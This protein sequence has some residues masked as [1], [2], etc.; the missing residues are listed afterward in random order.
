[1]KTKHEA[2]PPQQI[3]AAAYQLLGHKGY[4]ATTIKE[5]ARAADVAPGLVH[6]YFASKDDLLLAV[7]QEAAKRYVAEVEKVGNALATDT[8]ME[9]AFAQTRD[10]VN[11]EPE[12]YRL[13]YELLSLGLRN[14]KLLAGLSNLL[15]EGRRCIAQVIRQVVQDSQVDADALSPVLLACFDGLA[16]QKLAD[17]SFDLEGAYQMLIQMF[18]SQLGNG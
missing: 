10:R 14:P 8:L 12:W 18:K 13:R 2:K 3:I 15:A 9:Q 16:L 4:D 1:M 17:P 6:Y 7:L 5:I 11:Q